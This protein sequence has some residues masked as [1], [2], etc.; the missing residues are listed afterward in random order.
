[1]SRES[2]KA[3]K[4]QRAAYIDSLA[5][6]MAHPLGRA[7]VW[8]QL[9]RSGLYASLQQNNSGFTSYMIGRREVGLELLTDLKAHCFGEYRVMEDEA[10][11]QELRRRLAEQAATDSQED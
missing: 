10:L 1:M 9:E 6:V 2:E 3:A 11:A 8:S 4:R 5:H 7:F